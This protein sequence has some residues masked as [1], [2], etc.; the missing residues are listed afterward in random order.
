MKVIVFLQGKPLRGYPAPS[1]SSLNT[2]SHKQSQRDSEGQEELT[3]PG[4]PGVNAGYKPDN[5]HIFVESVSADINTH[6]H[7]GLQL[8]NEGSRDLIA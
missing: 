1:L 8:L 6:H 5:C 7:Q 4:D 3:V 2:Y